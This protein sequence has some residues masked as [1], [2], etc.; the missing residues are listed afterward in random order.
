[1]F[2]IVF[3]LSV[4]AQAQKGKSGGDESDGVA[5]TQKK[6]ARERF[7][8]IDW[9]RQNQERM[10]EQDSRY[11]SAGGGKS[12]AELD[13]VLQ[14]RQEAMP[15]RRDDTELGTLNSWEG[16]LQILLDNL[17][18]QGNRR[19]SLNVDIGLEGFYGASTGF[20]PLAGI[21]Q[22]RLEYRRMGGGLLL[23]PLG[24]SSQDSGLMVKGG[25]LTDTTNGF[26]V[27]G[28]PER[29][30]SSAY[31]GA[32]AK[33]YLLPFLGG[34]AEYLHGLGVKNTELQG[35]VKTS[36]FTYGGFLE[37]WLVNLEVM[38]QQREWIL[39]PDAGGAPRK[40]IQKGLGF[41]GSLFF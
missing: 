35:E 11:A 3:L 2:A 14:Y 6:R 16:R 9:I 18:N 37:I 27:D 26:F 21:S 17:I 15:F 33:L 34:R 30:F 25:Y 12:F 7:N 28:A 22:S 41:S 8:I 10:R 38:V 36:T 1:M 19:R 23:R 20:S 4:S 5:A 40:E 32:E 31:L 24:R 39:Q 13:L 29:V